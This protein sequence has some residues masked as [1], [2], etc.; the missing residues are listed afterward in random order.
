MTERSKTRETSSPLFSLCLCRL[1]GCSHA[2][3]GIVTHK[4][5]TP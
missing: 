4:D 2:A 3:A 1:M 5:V